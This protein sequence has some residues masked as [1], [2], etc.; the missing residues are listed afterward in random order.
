MTETDSIDELLDAYRAAVHAKD[1]DAF[2]GLYDGDVT[3]FDTWARWSYGGAGEWRVNVAEWFGSLGDD[4]VVVE[5]EDV[6]TVA[7]DDVAAVHAVVTYKSLAA[8]GRELRAMQNR[9]TWVLRRRDG[10]WRIV[11]EHTSAPADF[12]TMKVSLR[13]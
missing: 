1:V 2:I 5:W 12:E 4:R 8:D 3:V 9:L 13:R 6:H 11:H 10:A 7:G